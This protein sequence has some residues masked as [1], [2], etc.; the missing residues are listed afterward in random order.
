MTSMLVCKNHHHAAQ[1]R[2]EQMLN[3]VRKKLLNW[4]AGMEV[5][6]KD[7]HWENESNVWSFYHQQV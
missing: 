3:C 2:A 6:N 7:E 1:N 5:K 4:K